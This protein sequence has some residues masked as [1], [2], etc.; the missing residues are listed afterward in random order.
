MVVKKGDRVKVD[1]QESV[2]TSSWGQ[3]KH[4]AFALEDGRTV[5]DLTDEHVVTSRPEPTKPKTS[6]FGRMRRE[7][8]EP[9]PTDDVDLEE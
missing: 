2:V 6:L 9:L 8:I 5:F 7:E 4:R 1:D 3:G